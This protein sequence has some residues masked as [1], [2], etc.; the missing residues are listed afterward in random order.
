MFR[1]RQDIYVGGGQLETGWATF[2]VKI[3]NPTGTEWVGD[4][5][6]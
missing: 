4:R 3:G 1:G 5:H 2:I 6:F